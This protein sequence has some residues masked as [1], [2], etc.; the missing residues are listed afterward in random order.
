MY[1]AHHAEGR[2]KDTTMMLKE[3]EYHKTVYSGHHRNCCT[4]VRWNGSEM[5]LYCRYE[6]SK[7]SQH[8]WGKRIASYRAD[9][10]SVQWKAAGWFQGSC[11]RWSVRR[12]RRRTILNSEAGGGATLGECFALR[13]PTGMQARESAVL[14]R[15]IPAATATGAAVLP[16]ERFI[17]PIATC[18]AAK[19]P[20]VWWLW[21]PW[22][23][24]RQYAN[25]GMILEKVCSGK[26]CAAVQSAGIFCSSSHGKV[27]SQ[28]IFRLKEPAKSEFATVF[29]GLTTGNGGFHAQKLAAH[30]SHHAELGL[31]IRINFR[32]CEY[33]ENYNGNVCNLRIP[34]TGHWDTA[35]RNRIPMRMV[36]TKNCSLCEW[37][38]GH[39]SFRAVLISLPQHQTTLERGGHKNTGRWFSSQG[40]WKNWCRTKLCD[41]YVHR[42][43]WKTDSIMRFKLPVYPLWFW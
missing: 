5:R 21:F 22:V 37:N 18:S 39:T 38:I 19:K 28:R 2:G 34:E 15:S 7:F 17:S 12:I 40:N 43:R 30:T 6:F 31:R 35:G 11:S 1:G 16:A 25:A 9:S 24:W 42:I 36:D 33:Q 4:M 29:T 27:S 32:K 13:S 26:I 3:Q 20:T 14:N 41:S 8:P 10:V 23:V